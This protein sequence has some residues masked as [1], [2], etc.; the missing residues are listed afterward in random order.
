MGWL[1]VKHGQSTAPITAPF[2]SPLRKRIGLMEQGY[3]IGKKGRGI[4]FWKTRWWF[5]ICLFS[6]LPEQRFF[7]RQKDLSGG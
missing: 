2:C 7:D 3:A 5:Q 4:F 6:S 1:V